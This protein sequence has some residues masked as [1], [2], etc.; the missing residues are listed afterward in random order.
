[1][2]P[3]E[4]NWIDLEHRTQ[5]M[6]CRENRCWEKRKKKGQQRSP[7]HFFHCPHPSYELLP[8]PFC[9]HGHK[10]TLH[11]PFST[12]QTVSPRVQIQMHEPAPR[13]AH[14][15]PDS[16]WDICMVIF[17]IFSVDKEMHIDVVFR[18]GLRLVS[19]YLLRGKAYNTFQRR[20]DQS[21]RTIWK[22]QD[23]NVKKWNLICIIVTW[24]KLKQCLTLSLFLLWNN[25]WI[26]VF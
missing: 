14:P 25:I 9:V 3:R 2:R 7:H 22:S 18:D 6:L 12:P 20:S 8:R 23:A 21:R 1:M 10:L 5:Q 15:G 19:L 16:H 13:W 26:F 4:T 24:K 11:E 17:S